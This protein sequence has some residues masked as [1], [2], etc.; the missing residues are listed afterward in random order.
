M[1]RQ[2][3]KTL[4]MAN[5][6]ARLVTLLPRL[7]AV[8]THNVRVLRS[9][10]RWLLTSREHTNW[11]YDLTPLNRE[12]LAW[13][14]ANLVETSV[15]RVRGYLDEIEQDRELQAHI[16]YVSASSTR[17]GL[18][19]R[20]V[21]YGRRIGWY[22]LVR[23]LRPQHVVETGTDKGLGSVVLAAALL[24]NGKGRLTTIDINPNAGYLIAGRYS[25]VVDF[26]IG[27][28][29]AVLKGLDTGIDVFLHDSDHSA[30]YEAA[31]FAAITE[32]LEAG[33]L[34]MSDN[35]HATNVLSGWSE[36]QGRRFQ[37]FGERPEGHWYPGAG[38]GVSLPP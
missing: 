26:R 14:V 27:D 6:A 29:V 16:Q 30:E 17:R 11:T 23:C 24:R 35:A 28:S 12:H 2:Q 9:S 10:A 1:N 15:D 5:E 21:R 37:F 33:A 4:V 36:R 31:E 32:R 13:F 8:G 22:A 7:R 19:D 25:S 3:L 20:E 18:A 34:I 38:I